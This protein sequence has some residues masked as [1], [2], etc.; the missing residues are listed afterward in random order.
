MYTSEFA[1]QDISD[2]NLDVNA[3]EKQCAP[4]KS[5]SNLLVRLED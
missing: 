4:L 3:G 2:P 1:T 5:T